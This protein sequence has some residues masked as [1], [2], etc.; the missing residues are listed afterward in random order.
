MLERTFMKTFNQLGVS[1]T[2][3]EQLKTKFITEPTPIQEIAIPMIVN[4]EDFVAEA[5]TGSGK[6]LAFLLPI[7]DQIQTYKNIQCLVVS[8]TRELAMQITS[9]AQE[10]RPDLKA[11]CVYGG[12]DISTQ[13]RK[14]SNKVDIVIATPGRLMDHLKRGT[15][16]L[17]T[18]NFLVFDEIDQL[19]EM[20]FQPDLD[21]ILKYCPEKR[22]TLGFSATISKSVKKQAY[23]MMASPTFISTKTE[24]VIKKKINHHLIETTPRSKQSDLIKLLNEENPFLCI[25]FCRTRR[26]VDQLEVG[27][28]QAGFS[29]MK[30]HGGMPQ[31][32][33]QQTLKAFR[34]LSIQ[35]LIA[36]EVAS[37]GLDI[38]GVSHVIN[39][40]M[41]ESPESYVHRIGRTGRKDEY[42]KTYL[43]ANPEDESQLE[44]IK[45]A[46][47]L[48]FNQD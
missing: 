7:L 14:A 38:S 45:S 17:D 28:H 39:Y 33:R 16:K 25:I 32:K 19:I 24:T 8:P 4:K 6:T 23:K 42:G 34:G 18:L 11:L 40:D 36:T 20:G 10:L 41:P 21:F 30:F 2:L 43:F 27:L 37:R 15:I 1:D 31:N 29:C 35:Y 5:A 46:L 13:L 26:R 12:Q 47:Q 3:V 9:V 44:I 48:T 22:Q